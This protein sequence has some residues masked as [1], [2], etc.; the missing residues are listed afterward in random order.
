[1][2]G[3][4]A[5]I[6]GNVISG[7]STRAIEVNSG[8]TGVEITNNKIGTRIDGTVPAR[9]GV[10]CQ[11]QFGYDSSDWYGGWGISLAGT[12]ALIQFN[13][14]AGLQNLRS[15]FDTPPMAIEVFGADHQIL[16]NLIGVG[17]PGAAPGVCGQGIKFSGTNHEITTNIMRRVRKGFDNTDGALLWSDDTFTD[18]GGNTVR[19][20]LSIDGPEKLY[21]MGP[22]IGSTIRT[23]EP[24]VITSVSGMTVTGTAAAGSPCANCIIDFYIDDM[25]A[26]DE[27]LA[28]AGSLT[29]NGSGNFSGTVLATPGIDQGFRTMT[30]SV[31]SNQIGSTFAG[32][33]SEPSSTLYPGDPNIT[34]F[35]DGFESGNTLA[36]Q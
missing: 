16:D 13:L 15:T 36:W 23:F 7:A 26:N 30:T 14:I 2:N 10:E 4:N 29:A 24:A 27:A 11:A 19:G 8:T 28:Y 18:D 17:D 25:D 12:G 20:N 9:P 34:I 21:E 3:D 5:V 35:I 6:T 31:L 22:M 1:M 32:T 33:T